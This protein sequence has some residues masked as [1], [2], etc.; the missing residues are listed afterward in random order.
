MNDF[1]AVQFQ[2]YFLFIAKVARKG[3]RHGMR[4]ESTECGF[5]VQGFPLRAVRESAESW[6]CRY[7]AVGRYRSSS[8]YTLA[9]QIWLPKS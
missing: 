3:A 1:R 5:A 6:L 2:S 9:V 4:L 8:F 7:Y